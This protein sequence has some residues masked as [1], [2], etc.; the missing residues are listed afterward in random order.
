MARRPR[1][2]VVNMR[3]LGHRRVAQ[4]LLNEL[5]EP[6][7][8]RLGAIKTRVKGVMPRFLQV[9]VARQTLDV[10]SFL[11][12]PFPPSR[13]SLI[14][15]FSLAVFSSF[16]YLLPLFSALSRLFLS[17]PVSIL[18]I[19]LSFALSLLSLARPV[20]AHVSASTWECTM[21]RSY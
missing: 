20:L 18:S 3:V 12:C 5:V 1:E 13:F 9:A 19:I 16:P 4:H 11:F 21:S 6:L 17:L 15:F 2:E 7:F 10:S 14:F 8:P